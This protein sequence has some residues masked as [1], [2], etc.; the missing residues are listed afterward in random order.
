MKYP[1][2]AVLNLSGN[3]GKSTLA[4]NLL[5]AHRPEAKFVSVETINTTSADDVES[6]DVEEFAASEFKSIFREIMFNDSVIV[7]VGASNVLKF[8]QELTRFKSASNEI[9]LIVVPT[10]PADKQ[11]KDTIATID[12][13]QKLGFSADKIRVVFNMY[14]SADSQDV[15]LV[16]SHV[17]GYAMSDGKNKATYEP[18]IVI[19][20]NEVF[21][22]MKTTRKNIRELA[23]DPTDW[24]AKRSEAKAAGDANAL[25]AAMDG[26]MAHDLAMTAQANLAAAADLLFGGKGR[27]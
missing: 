25:E 20:T 6:L 7:D 1:K 27:K 9:D 17:L 4:V 8:M 10:V 22:L 5:A 12:W 11:Q 18:H 23:N 2:I 21:E 26:Q 14:E 3:V 19:A 16:Y 13:L 15:E 24:R